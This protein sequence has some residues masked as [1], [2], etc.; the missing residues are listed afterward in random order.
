[1]Q[2]NPIKVKAFNASHGVGSEVLIKHANG[3]QTTEVMRW[4]EAEEIAKD[5]FG[6]WLVGCIDV[7]NFNQVVFET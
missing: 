6:V 3:T 5:V 2:S 4:H 1:M 7:V